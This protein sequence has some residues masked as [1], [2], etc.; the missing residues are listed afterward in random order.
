MK[1]KKLMLVSLFMLVS[2]IFPAIIV[3][4]VPTVEVFTNGGFE[5]GDLPGWSPQF[6]T[7]AAADDTKAFSGTYSCHLTA[8][9]TA[10]METLTNP[11]VSENTNYWYSLYVWLDDEDVTS[12]HIMIEYYDSADQPVSGSS[13]YALDTLAAEWEVNNFFITTPA[14]T[15]KATCTVVVYCSDAYEL[16]IDDFSLNTENIIPEFAAASNI[17]FFVSF[18]VICFTLITKSRKK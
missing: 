14:T 18:G 15:A 6:L 1:N 9:D 7:I 5:T 2:F 3:Q 10:F 16:W 17:L 8:S 11:A 4:S 13:S 12:I